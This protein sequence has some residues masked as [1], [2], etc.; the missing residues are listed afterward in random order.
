MLYDDYRLIAVDH[1]DHER[2]GDVFRGYTKWLDDNR[3]AFDERFHDFMTA[4][5]H[6]DHEDRRALHDMRFRSAAVREG[7][8]SDLRAVGIGVELVLLGAYFDRELR[9]RYEGV[10]RYHIGIPDTAEQFPTGSHG[11]L[12]IDEAGLLAS[13]VIVH[14]LEFSRGTVFEIVFDGEFDYTFTE[15]PK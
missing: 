5:W 10:R 4:P 13:G 14:A 11:D 7:S 2:M 3:Q 1:V 6:Y 15:L 12:L 9:L 8:S